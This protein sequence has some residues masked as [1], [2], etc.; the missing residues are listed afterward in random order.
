MLARRFVQFR[1]REPN[2][3]CEAALGGGSALRFLFLTRRRRHLARDVGA[4]HAATCAWSPTSPD[5]AYPSET[6]NR[7]ILRTRAFR[8]GVG[9]DRRRSSGVSGNRI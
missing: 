9:N 5:L 8:R 2:L 1:Q 7:G 3:A 6:T 4:C